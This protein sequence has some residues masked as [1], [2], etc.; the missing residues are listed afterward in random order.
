M[1][2]L[3]P[4]SLSQ[5]QPGAAAPPYGSGPL[6][7]CALLAYSG[8]TNSALAQDLLAATPFYCRESVTWTGINA[9]QHT[10]GA[11]INARMGVYSNSGGR[12]VTLLADSGSVSFPASTGWRTGTISLAMTPGWYWLAIVFSGSGNAVTLDVGTLTSQGRF[13]A[14]FGWTSAVAGSNA[15]LDEAQ[16][17]YGSHSFA[18][19]PASFPSITGYSG[20]Q[21]T[22]ALWLSK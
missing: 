3:N 22:P 9:Y 19:L 21:N 11:G 7:P 4:A 8:L 2:T 17:F 18:A 5:L 6:Y 10:N 15:K 12:P 13:L 20:T 16:G 14:D 1:P